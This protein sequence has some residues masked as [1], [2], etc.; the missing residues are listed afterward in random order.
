VSEFASPF[1]NGV[2]VWDT[3]TNAPA[4]IPVGDYHK[5]VAGGRFKPYDQS[6]VT[7]QQGPT[8]V[9]SDAATGAGQVAAGA[10]FVSSTPRVAAAAKADQE[11]AFDSF[12]EKLTATASGF[13]DAASFGLLK[14]RS[15]VGDARRENLPGWTGLGHVAA[16]A[17][18]FINPT[19]AGPL[20]GGAAK[21]ATGAGRLST[22]GLK[23]GGAASKIVK[24]AIQ[25]GVENATFTAA[26]SG[27]HDAVDALIEDKPFASETLGAAVGSDLVVGAVTGSVLGGMGGFFKNSASKIKARE[28]MTA[29]GG[30]LDAASTQSQRVNQVY[31]EALSGWDTALAKHRQT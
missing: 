16:A 4:Y 1:E 15:L 9:T 5:S 19:A 11:A 30:L 21:I 6:V 20:L 27:A 13:V 7:T 25:E 17:T 23:A 12:A 28:Y 29:Q 14:D 3:Q 22:A 2:M 18:A 24:R 31:S 8:Q 10:Q 26:A